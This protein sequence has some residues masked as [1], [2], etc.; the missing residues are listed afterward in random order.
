M[1]VTSAAA[2]VPDGPPV[3]GPKGVSH[4]RTASEAN[5]AVATISPRRTSG[6]R[7]AP[8]DEWVVAVLA[9]VTDRRA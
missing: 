8:G 5:P 3:S 6:T 4:G 1:P 7:E 9:F 2:A